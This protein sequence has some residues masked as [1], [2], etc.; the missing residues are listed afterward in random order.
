MFLLK[1]SILII[2]SLADI[3]NIQGDD[4]KLYKFP[5]YYEAVLQGKA[6]LDS[7]T[8]VGG[9]FDRKDPWGYFS[10]GLKALNESIINRLKNGTNA[11]FIFLS[12]KNQEN[13]KKLED[14]YKKWQDKYHPPKK[15]EKMEEEEDLNMAP[16]LK[17]KPKKKTSSKKKTNPKKKPSPKKKKSKK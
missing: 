8:E 17:I 6:K 15:E 16:Y 2:F 12:A 9:K 14:A 1:L 4:E 7:K 3:L 10:N 11:N 13:L 5:E